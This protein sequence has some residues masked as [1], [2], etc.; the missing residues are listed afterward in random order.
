MRHGDTMRYLGTTPAQRAEMLRIIGVDDVETLLERI[1]SKAR[2]GG[3]LGLPPALA[4]AELIARMRALAERNAH[5]DDYVSFLGA[6]AYDHYV[7]AVIN[8]LLLRSEFFTAYTP[9]QSESCQ[10]TFRTCV[11]YLSTCSGLTVLSGTNSS[12]AYC[13]SA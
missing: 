9:Y 2:L 10:D 5:A 12:V 6:G 1:P 4:E 8:H 11:E 7:P 3:D 13:D